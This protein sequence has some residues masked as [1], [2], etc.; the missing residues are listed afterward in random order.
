[1]LGR[2][3]QRVGLARAQAMKSALVRRLGACL[4]VDGAPF[5][6]FPEA[7]T[8]AVYGEAALAA[9][10]GNER[11]A[12]AIHAVSRAFAAVGP[13]FFRDTPQDELKGWLESIHGVGEFTTGFVLYRGLGRFERLPASPGFTRAAEKVYRRP[14]ST[15][16]LE[17]M[18]AHYGPWAGHWALYL[19]ASGFVATAPSVPTVS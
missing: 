8:V 17:R 14:L 3:D 2:D 5:W 12:R 19:W 15:A 16:D 4:T 7:A 18:A 13:E 11:K 10:L 9:L 1:M 6:A